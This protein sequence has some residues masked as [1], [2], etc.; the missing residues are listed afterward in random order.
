M[1]SKLVKVFN[2]GEENYFKLNIG[3]KSSLEFK[4]CLSDFL[5]DIGFKNPFF[6]K[7]AKE[8]PYSLKNNPAALRDFHKFFEN[9]TFKIHIMFSE[10][11][12]HMVV[13]CSKGG[14]QELNRFIKKHFETV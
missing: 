11:Y 4:K 5:E 14:R 6:Q 13:K 9:E 8:G 2:Q 7:F 12:L 1:K 3:S 10:E